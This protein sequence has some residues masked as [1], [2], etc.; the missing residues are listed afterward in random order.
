MSRNS[1][2]LVDPTLRSLAKEAKSFKFIRY[3]A[4]AVPLLVLIGQDHCWRY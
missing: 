4:L 2:I 3:L 1:N